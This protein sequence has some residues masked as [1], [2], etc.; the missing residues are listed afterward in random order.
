MWHTISAPAQASEAEEEYETAE[1]SIADESN[2]GKE[3][4][5]PFCG[6]K[7]GCR[8]QYSKRGYFGKSNF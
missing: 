5:P 2:G 1:T 4:I 3:S 7:Y 8:K 6:R